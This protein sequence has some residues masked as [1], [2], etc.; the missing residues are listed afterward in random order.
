[1]KH[2]EKHKAEN[3]LHTKI[4]VCL[5][6]VLLMMPMIILASA[7]RGNYFLFHS[8]L[9]FAGGLAWTNTEY[10]FHRFVMHD[11][12]SSKGMAKLLSHK[13]HHTEPADIRITTPH[14]IL[15]TTG[16]IVL[17]GLS[18]WLNNYFTL[19]C[20]Y[21]AGFTA[22]CLIHVV[23][24]HTWSK[25]IFPH[26]HS[27]H[28]LH[29]CKHSN[30]YFGVTLTWWDHLFG[31]IP[32]NEKKISNRI[33]EFYYKKENDHNKKIISLN[34]ILDEKIDFGEKRPA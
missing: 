33:L 25:K 14:R 21:F 1:M 11:S 7:V 17:I 32:A 6:F 5:W 30:K 23:L 26:L 9:L 15:M 24:H 4:N 13:H 16:S 8:L 22:F 29:H 19:L 31:T 27:V 20:G 28:I 12:D 3:I 10:F 34:S 18:I 2:S